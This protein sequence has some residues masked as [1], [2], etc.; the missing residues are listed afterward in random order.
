MKIDD[1]AVV[2]ASSFDSAIEGSHNSGGVVSIAIKLHQ[3]ADTS[4]QNIMEIS[5]IPGTENIDVMLENTQFIDGNLHPIL[6]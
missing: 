5:L 4:E 1:H 6:K 3:L 2:N